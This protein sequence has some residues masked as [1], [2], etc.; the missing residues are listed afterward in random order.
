[1]DSYAW[2]FWECREQVPEHLKNF[3]EIFSVKKQNK[4]WGVVTQSFLICIIS[5]GISSSETLCQTR[6]EFPLFSAA[7]HLQTR[8]RRQI[9]CL[10]YRTRRDGQGQKR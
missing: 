10:L 6:Q 1:M 3:P 5:S 9:I 2:I 8:C 7:G 4:L